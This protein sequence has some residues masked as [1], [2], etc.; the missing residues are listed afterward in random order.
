[1]LA[2]LIVPAVAVIGLGLD[3]CAQRGGPS[4]EKIWRCGKCNGYLG[5][6]VH[7]PASC[8]HCNARISNGGPWGNNSARDQNSKERSPVASMIVVLV[9]LAL[10][11]GLGFYVMNSA[12]TQS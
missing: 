5:N 1:L 3:A 10:A 9:V 8:H 7:P 4:F 2:L 11:V 6:G 12:S